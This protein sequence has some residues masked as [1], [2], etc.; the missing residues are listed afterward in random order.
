MRRL[1]ALGIPVCL[2]LSAGCGGGGSDP[3]VVV[4]DLD[5]VLEIFDKTLKEKPPAT[6]NA[7]AAKPK[8]GKADA[9]KA[10]AGKA[11]AGKA[12]AGKAD[13]GK[14]KPAAKTEIKEVQHDNKKTADF[15]KRF[16]K[17]LNAAKVIQGD[18]I[19]VLMQP[20]GAIEGF[21]DKDKDMRKSGAAEKTLF[22]IQ[23]DTEKNRLIATQTVEGST[24]HRD[25]H[26]HRSG[27][28]F[29][30]GGFFMG[31]MLGSMMGRQRGFY[32][33]RRPGFS[34]MRMNKPGYHRAA[35]TKARTSARTRAGRSSARSG[36]S[37][38]FRGGK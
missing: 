1:F 4:A 10:K 33:G 31:Y 16:A 15:L 3:K 19:G 5:K 26:Y 18:T 35:V 14:P 20:S 24:Y 22:T 21:I 30:G 27:F 36:G 29:G 37:R 28:G 9:G 2:F 17:N 11:K 8:A 12:D 13:A 6:A 25:R 38:G 34:S 7:K 23:I 32:G